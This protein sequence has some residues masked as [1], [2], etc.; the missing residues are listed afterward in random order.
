[1]EIVPEERGMEEIS[2]N[3]PVMQRKKCYKNCLHSE[4]VLHSMVTELTIL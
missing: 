2:K 4:A 3:L 1:M